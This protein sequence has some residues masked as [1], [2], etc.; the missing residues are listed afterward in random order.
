MM[1]GSSSEAVKSGGRSCFHTLPAG[2]RAVRPTAEPDVGLQD[3]TPASRLHAW[4][5]SAIVR[6]RP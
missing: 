2:L 5:S 6:R 1:V 3:L 4:C